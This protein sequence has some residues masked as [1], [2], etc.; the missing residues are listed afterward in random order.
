MFCAGALLPIGKDTPNIE[1]VT[2]SYAAEP[3][4]L[5]FIWK[6]QSGIVLFTATFSSLNMTVHLLTLAT[7]V[8]R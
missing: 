8:S 4:I 7:R 1:L 5:N 6:G 2:F 3:N